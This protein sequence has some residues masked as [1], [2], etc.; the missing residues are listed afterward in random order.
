MIQFVVWLAILAGINRYTI[1]VVMIYAFHRLRAKKSANKSYFNEIVTD[2]D[3][4]FH[5]ILKTIGV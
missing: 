4:S 5:R 3:E 1:S 2:F